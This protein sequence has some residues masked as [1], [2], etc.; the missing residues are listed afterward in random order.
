MVLALIMTASLWQS[1]SDSYPD[2]TY[3]TDE[4]NTEDYLTYPLSPSLNVNSLLYATSSGVATNSVP[5][6]TF[7]GVTAKAITPVDKDSEGPLDPQ[8]NYDNFIKRYAKAR[9]YLLAYRKS[10]MTDGDAALTQLP[11]FS[12]LMGDDDNRLNCLLSTERT[13]ISGTAQHIGKLA[14]PQG[15]TKDGSL[16]QLSTNGS[17]FLLDNREW[18]DNQN[19]KTQTYYW[20]KKKYEKVGYNFF[21]YYINKA[22][23]YGFEKQQD[24][25]K[26]DLELNGKNDIMV[27]VAP[28]VTEEMLKEE[29]STSVTEEQIR[30][31]ILN[32]GDGAYSTYG[33]VHSVEPKIDLK[34]AL[35]YLKFRVKLMDDAVKIS[36]QDIQVTACTRGKLVVASRDLEKTRL[37]LTELSEEKDI[38]VNAY[39]SEE[40]ISTE[41]FKEVGEGILVPPA[42]SYKVKILIQQTHVKTSETDTNPKGIMQTWL[43]VDCTPEKGFE[44]GKIYVLD[45]SV[46]G[47]TRIDITSDLESWK[48]GIGTVINL[49]DD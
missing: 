20:N 9:F 17:L 45:L 7:S 26:I 5:D 23:V 35:A 8:N 19:Y 33:A 21:A 36:I 43:E 11:D 30:K 3:S 34:H 29:Y 13:Y 24:C 31:T 25:V 44:A 6:V 41:D 12:Q 42:D 1:C 39:L 16:D 4:K 10:V 27:G 37:G 14:I 15:A 38:S 46:Y 2:L 32:Y 28:E 40:D 48:S 22:N 49:F 47:T 18:E